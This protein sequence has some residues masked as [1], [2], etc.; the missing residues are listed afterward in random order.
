MASVDQLAV[1]NGIS[2]LVTTSIVLP[3]VGMGCLMVSLAIEASATP[4]GM[5]IAGILVSLGSK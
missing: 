4:V 1:A 3:G 2:G 5:R